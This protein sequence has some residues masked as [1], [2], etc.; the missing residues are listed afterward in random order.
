MTTKKM[1]LG[2]FLEGFH[3]P[4][5]NRPWSGSSSLDWMD[6]SVYVDM[7]R[8]LERGCFDFMLIEDSNYIPDVYGGTTEVDLRW[9][10]RA[11]KHDPS[12]L[13]TLISQAT[14]K[15]GV[16]VTVATNQTNPF[17]LARLMSSLDH[18]S[19]GRIGWN[20]VTGSNDRAAQNFGHDRQPPHDERYDMADEFVS[21]ADALWNSWE[22]DAFVHDLET[23]VYVDG[24]KVHA[25][26]FEGEYYKTRGPL[27]TIPSPQRRPVI[28]QAGISAKGQAFAAKNADTVVATAS[29]VASMRRITEGIRNNAESIGRDPGDIKVL[30]LIE[31]VFGETDKEAEDLAD[32]IR[33]QNRTDPTWGLST[34]SGVSGIDLSKLDLDKPVP[35]D[36]TTNGH[37]GQLQDWIDSGVHVRDL[38]P[39]GSSR[40]AN[41]TGSPATVADKMQELVEATGFDGYLI[42]KPAVTR[43]FISELVDGL[44]PELQSRGQMQSGYPNKTF[45]ENLLAF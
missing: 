3:V 2:F 36:L 16:V 10:R 40:E 26:D 20:I 28:V 7:A 24:S 45:R 34:L 33:E 32:R 1:H 15:I 44:A 41:F 19:H 22:D 27:N 42:T 6:G 31:P 25:I 17:H 38:D 11:P 8:D 12:V 35:A 39:S 23:G 14:S 37:Q 21:A 13:A 4:A 29:D 5:W 30:F 18:V 9:G 43:R